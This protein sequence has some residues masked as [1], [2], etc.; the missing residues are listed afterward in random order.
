MAS[1]I[2]QRLIPELRKLERNN[3][4]MLAQA[5]FKITMLPSVGFFIVTPK[6][7]VN[8]PGVEAMEKQEFEEKIEAMAAIL[9]W[10]FCFEQDCH[11]EALLY[12]QSE[13][14]TGELE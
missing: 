13:E 14:I 11:D 9:G 10:K 3:V 1:H 12:F 8:M 4:Y 2:T 7:S 6:S 5:K